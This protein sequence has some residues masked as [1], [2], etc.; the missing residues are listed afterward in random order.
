MRDRYHAAD[1]VERAQKARSLGN[2]GYKHR[3]ESRASV[4]RKAVTVEEREACKKTYWNVQRR[5]IAVQIDPGHQLWVLKRSAPISP[6]EHEHSDF[7]GSD[8]QFQWLTG[9]TCSGLWRWGIV[10]GQRHPLS[11]NQ[12]NFGWCWS[13]AGREN[14]AVL[15]HPCCLRPVSGLLL[16]KAVH[17]PG[18]LVS[19]PA[20][21]MFV[22][23]IL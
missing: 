6:V 15:H 23:S 14:H 12:L 1:T 11:I 13:R 18:W 22:L 20:S 21:G 4:W 16:S 7:A 10:D 8:I 9:W 2:S 19:A 5:V 17:Q 3:E